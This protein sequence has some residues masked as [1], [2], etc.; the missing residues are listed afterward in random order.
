MNRVHLLGNAAD[1]NG[2]F[3]YYS[4][5]FTVIQA[6]FENNSAENGGVFCIRR[7]NIKVADNSSFIANNASNQGGVM[8]IRGVTL[9]M[10]MDSVIANNTAGSSGKL[11]Y[12]VHVLVRILLMDLKLSLIQSTHCT[13]YNF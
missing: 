8:N 10:D 13:V 5:N 12:S 6:S 4:V 3:F 2:G 1:D 11:M 9:T 7:S